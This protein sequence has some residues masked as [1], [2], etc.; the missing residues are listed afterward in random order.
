MRPVLI[1]GAGFSGSTVA[2]VLAEAGYLVKVIDRRPHLAGNA[3]DELDGYGIRFH[4][5][6]PHLFHT[7]NTK[8]IDF[9]SR[10]TEWIPYKHKVKALLS[11]GKYVTLPVNRETVDIVGHINVV[12]I[13]Y[14][15]YTR[16]MWNISLEELDPT[17]LQRIPMRDD[18]NDYYF[19]ND[20][21]Q[22]L[23]VKGYTCLVENI[24]NHPNI[25][26]S[27][28]TPFDKKIEAD[29]CHIFNSM[30]I[31]EY[32]DYCFGILPYRSI[33]FHH[34]SVPVP[35]LFPVATVNFTHEEPFTRVTEWKHLPGHGKN[36]AWTSITVEEPCDFKDNNYERYYP[37]KD[38][39]GVNRLLFQAYQEIT[40]LHMTFIGRCGLYSYLDMHQAI[41]SSLA[42]AHQFLTGG[43]VGKGNGQ[44]GQ[45]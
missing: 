7:S 12:D 11:D 42:I 9:L 36:L 40:P 28:S 32:S 26:V 31:D 33:K 44:Q 22:A 2:R 8:V 17:I 25:E 24:L 38:L 39:E 5:Y 15:P 20:K 19:P 6:G 10:F 35:R 3:F 4:R 43:H 34:S 27:L 45:V 37:V 23:P 18:M 1:V 41:N 14:R 13:L 29:F 16:K 21:F 30:S